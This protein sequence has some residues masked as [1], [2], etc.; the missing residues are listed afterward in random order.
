M[1]CLS[2]NRP[3]PSF[4]APDEDR[5]FAVFD[6]NTAR[7]G[8]ELGLIVIFAAFSR[9]ALALRDEVA[10]L[11][12]AVMVVADVHVSETWMA[13]RDGLITCMLFD[14]RYLESRAAEGLPARM[15]SAAA[16]PA[17]VRLGGGANHRCP[18]DHDPGEVALPVPATGT[19]IRLAV[20]SA[21]EARRACLMRNDI[22]PNP[23]SGVA[24]GWFG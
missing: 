3:R 2:R 20:L 7:S 23:G 17:I 12:C 18:D 15:R 14:A 24:T 21:I 5:L 22:R 19:E 6:E 8:A 13:A 11:G 4:D 1:S 10:K 9:S 16:H